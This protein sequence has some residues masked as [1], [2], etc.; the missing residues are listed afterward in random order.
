MAFTVR[1]LRNGIRDHM[2]HWLGRRGGTTAPPIIV[3]PPPGSV[4]APS[5]R[6]ASVPSEATAAITGDI[7]NAIVLEDL[8]RQSWELLEWMILDPDLWS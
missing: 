8:E 7:T 5:I 3:S 2:G 4:G 6:Q 1:V